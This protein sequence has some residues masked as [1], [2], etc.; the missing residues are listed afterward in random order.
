MRRSDLWRILSWDEQWERLYSMRT[1]LYTLLKA[2]EDSAESR[3]IDPETLVRYSTCVYV[4]CILYI[5]FIYVCIDI[6]LFTPYFLLIP[7]PIQLA[8]ERE[9][10]HQY[11]NVSNQYK[12]LQTRLTVA[13]GEYQDALDIIDAKNNNTHTH[14][15]NNTGSN[16][17]SSGQ[18]YDDEDG[19]TE[20]DH[21]RVIQTKQHIDTLTHELQETKLL[22]DSTTA[23]LQQYKQKQANRQIYIPEQSSEV[24][25]MF[26]LN[27]YTRLISEAKDEKELKDISDYLLLLLKGCQRVNKS[28][29]RRKV[30][31]EE[32]GS[33]RG[34]GRG[35]SNMP[36]K[37]TQTNVYNS[38]ES[39]SMSQTLDRDGDDDD[40]DE[41]NHDADNTT[42]LRGTQDDDGDLDDT[43]TSERRPPQINS[44]AEELDVMH[45]ADTTDSTEAA[46]AAASSASAVA[47]TGSSQHK[48]SGLINSYDKYKRIPKLREFIELFTI[49]ACE[50][51]DSLINNYKIEPP[52]TPSFTP[53]E[54]VLSL[55]LTPNILKNSRAVIRAAQHIIALEYSTEPNIRKLCYQ[56][57]I[58]DGHISTRPTPK[59]ETA[60]TA[61]SELFGI[62][63]LD[64]K[65]IREFI[66]GKDKTLYLKLHEAEKQGLLTITIHLP[67]QHNTALKKDNKTNITSNITESINYYLYNKKLLPLFMPSLLLN[68]DPYPDIRQ[69]YDILR[70]EILQI[71]CEKFLFPMLLKSI[72]RYLLQISREN[73]IEE[74][75]QNFIH[76]LSIGAYIP[77]IENTRIHIKNTLL[78]TPKTTYY[79]NIISIHIINSDKEPW[80]ICY[81]DKYGLLK[82]SILIPHESNINKKHELLMLFIYEYKPNVIVINASGGTL[83][84]GLQET[85]EKR[86]LP[87]VCFRSK[88]IVYIHIMCII[89][90]CC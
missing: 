54:A 39:I 89:E 25:R 6:T 51:G 73:V 43:A 18:N 9:I 12:S 83:A 38:Q 17:N 82:G 77:P 19:A 85:L 8:E 42:A 49:P 15:Y 30:R 84:K 61:Y 44:T 67:E 56:S 1:K 68:Q 4:Y 31:E 2:I 36:V 5:A 75:G 80:C 50:F 41:F 27:R 45:I 26:P 64:H 71:L 52:P 37:V 58:D 34:S 22:Y 35:G 88:Y 21:N 72:N 3:F 23:T 86:L 40:D 53:E 10:Q 48:L 78:Y 47:H 70:I 87:Q 28:S 69:R 90:I 57:V 62:H 20:E 46:D 29:G 16:S 24:L 76:T 7:I 33:E 74:I 11:N 81:L 60:I 65:P 66:Y 59:G 13:E 55:S 79:Y 63:Y 14:D 32:R